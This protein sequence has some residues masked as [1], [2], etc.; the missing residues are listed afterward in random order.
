[1]LN[2]KFRVLYEKK[3]KYSEVSSI[4]LKMYLPALNY[5]QRFIVEI[6][7]GFGFKDLSKLEFVLKSTN[8]FI[9]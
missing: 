9:F 6:C 3:K 2:W 1:M 5:L 8:A 4:F 7:V